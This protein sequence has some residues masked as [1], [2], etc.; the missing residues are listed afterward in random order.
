MATMTLNQYLSQVGSAWSRRRGPVAADLLSLRHPHVM[1]ARLQL[2]RPEDEVQ[3]VLEPPLDELVAA[4]LRCLWAMA[5]RDFGEAHR[6]QSA[7]VSCFAKV[8]VTHKDDNWALPVMNTIC[9]DLRRVALAADLDRTRSG[10]GH[11]GEVLEKAAEGLMSCFRVCAGDT[12]A[13]MDDTKRWGMLNLVN[14]L[15]KIYFRV[16]KLHLCKPLIRAIESLSF[17]GDFSLSQLVTYRYYTGRKAMFDCDY[18]AAEEA[19]DFAFLRCHRACRNNKRL[20][21]IYLIPV[22]MLLGHMPQEQ[23]LA[24]YNLLQFSEVVRAVKEGN[25]RRL[26]D[27]MAAHQA[28]FIKCGIYLILEKLRTITYRNLFKKVYLLTASV[29]I[30]IARFQ[31]ALL[32]TGADQDID[33]DETS[34]ILANLIYEGR[35]KGYISHSH[36]KLVL[37]KKEPFPALS[38]GVT[39]S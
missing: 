6:C 32:A 31:A 26:S 21:L 2:E 12:R 28:F 23:L 14:Q 9:L 34:C 17:R 27:A 29:Q 1:S 25:P 37:S 39:V 4:H 10:Q 36:Q 5:N 20:I 19:L 33:A 7:V 13:E 38:A 24:K 8:F 15:F 22:K 30:D 16:N 11:P 35:M 3:D 18:K